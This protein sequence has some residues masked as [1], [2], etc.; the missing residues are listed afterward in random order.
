MRKIT[1]E[2]RKK[3]AQELLT[4][5]N[6]N[7]CGIGLKQLKTRL[8]DNNDHDILCLVLDIEFISCKAKLTYNTKSSSNY[9]KRKEL[10]IYD[11]IVL[12]E[13]NK[14]P[15]GFG[16]SDISFVNSIVYFDFVFGQVSWHSMMDY[17]KQPKYNG[18]WDNNPFST[19]YKVEKYIL[20]NNLLV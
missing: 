19:V 13:K 1:I 20:D 15:Y 14:I 5:L 9:Y 4:Y 6:D 3:K 12:A 10:L 2:Q 17:K 8:Q 16:E 7:I 11:L 18:K